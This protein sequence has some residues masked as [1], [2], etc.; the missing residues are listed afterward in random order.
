MPQII[1]CNCC[2]TA[3]VETTEVLTEASYYMCTMCREYCE[4]IDVDVKE[5][6]FK[7]EMVTDY[8]N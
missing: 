8:S 3:K 1:Y 7:K 2:E 4:H 5:N 6:N